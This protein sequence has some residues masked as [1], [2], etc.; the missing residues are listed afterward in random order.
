ML[1]DSEW[2]PWD[3][4]VEADRGYGSVCWVWTRPLPPTGRTVSVRKKAKRLF[5]KFVGERAEGQVWMHLC[6]RY[7]EPNLCVRP[8]H[9]ALGTR[10]AN[11]THW[12]ALRRAAG[13]PPNTSQAQAAR[14]GSHHTVESRRK[15]SETRRQRYGSQHG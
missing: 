12:H 1:P 14:L 8:D 9:I 7:N 15:I 5:A 10:S 13:V 3:E 2:F 6:E 11:M 4:V